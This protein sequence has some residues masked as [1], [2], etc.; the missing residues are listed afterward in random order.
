MKVL[1]RIELFI[2]ESPLWKFILVL[3]SI[4]L[5]KTGIWRIPNLDMSRSIAENP[6]VNPFTHPDQ[7]FMFWSWLGPFM[8][9]LIGA[10]SQTAFFLFHF[11]FSVAFTWLFIKLVI[12]RFPDPIARTSLILFSIIPVSATAYFW[13]SLDSITLFIMLFALA[14]PKHAVLTLVT[15]FALGMQHFEQGFFA[16]GGLLFAVLLSKKYDRE[17]NYS[18]KFCVLLFSG[19]ILGKLFLIGLFQYHEIAVNSGRFYWV[20]EHLVR[21]LQQFFFHFHH[22][23]WSMLGLGW[24]IALKYSDLG[25]KAIPFFASLL[26]LMILLA[27]CEDQ[28]RVLS[29]VTFLLLSVFWFFNERFL[30]T[31]SKKEVSLA[32]LVWAIMPWHWVFV[33]QPKWSA[34]PYDVAYLLNTLFGWFDMPANLESWPFWN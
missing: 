30:R 33:G 2:F 7:H 16:T 23:I 17:F 32:F 15:G 4:S 13:V 6:F 25:R 21:I 22:I 3:F 27:L 34:F 19:V 12:S 10:Q 14:Y 26:G 11:M 5:F 24:L 31:L 28:T 8:A 20:Q 9:W 18:L 1:D 29:I